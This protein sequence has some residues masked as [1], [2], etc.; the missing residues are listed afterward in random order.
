[1]SCIKEISLE[2]VDRVFVPGALSEPEDLKRNIGKSFE[3]IG[4][5]LSQDCV[6]NTRKVWLHDLLKHNETELDRMILS[7]KAFLFNQ[8]V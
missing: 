2:L 7:V 4:E 5:A 6:G 1:M 3:K 8:P